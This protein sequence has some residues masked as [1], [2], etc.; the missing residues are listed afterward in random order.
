MHGLRRREPKEV[1]G[2]SAWLRSNDINCL[3]DM[4]GA[5]GASRARDYDAT[6]YIDTATH[7]RKL[8]KVIMDAV[9][10]QSTPGAFQAGFQWQPLEVYFIPCLSCHL[11]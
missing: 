4:S 1:A 5:T 2:L 11:I 6:A 7:P 3:G 9:V 10:I 8:I